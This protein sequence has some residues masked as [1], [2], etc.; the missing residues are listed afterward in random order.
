MTKCNF[1]MTYSKNQN[2]F[3][4]IIFLEKS[5]HFSHHIPIR[6]K[7]K[8][9]VLKLLRRKIAQPLDYK[10]NEIKPTQQ[11]IHPY[12]V[13]HFHGTIAC[14]GWAAWHKNG[15]NVHFNGTSVLF[16]IWQLDVLSLLLFAPLLLLSWF[17]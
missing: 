16:L 15:T 14:V 2:D 4:C 9:T 17:F 11:H 7:M 8:K 1:V 10:P 12:F 13:Q 5:K 6:Y 3:I